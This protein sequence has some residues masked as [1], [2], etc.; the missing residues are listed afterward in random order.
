MTRQNYYHQRHMREREKVDE[1][2]VVELVRIERY[3]QPRL[4][5]RKLWLGLQEEL[6]RAGVLLGRDRFFKVLKGHQLLIKRRK[7]RCRTTDSRHGFK[8]YT[9]LAK[10]LVLTGPH[11][12]L[13]SDITYLRTEAGF[14]Y[15][16]LVMDAYSRKIVGYDCSSSLEAVGARRALKMALAQ[17]PAGTRTM[18]HSDRGTQYCCHEYVALLAK[19]GVAISMTEENHCY[20]NARAERLNGILKQEYGLGETLA[21]TADART[22]ARQAVMLYNTHRPHTALGYRCPGEVHEATFDRCGT[23]GVM[24]VAGSLMSGTPVAN[25]TVTPPPIPQLV[26]SG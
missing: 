9:N 12:L 18:H 2:L 20:E 1:S 7:S 21:T 6:Q 16:A 17:L 10:D 25:A 13:V 8:V 19:A 5:G 4:G 22:L 3:R 24:P 14:M 15:L 26:P 11:E 23:G